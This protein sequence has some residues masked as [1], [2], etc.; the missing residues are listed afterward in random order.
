M[1]ERRFESSAD[2][3]G[4][5]FREPVSISGPNSGVA[6]SGDADGDEQ[7]GDVCRLVATVHCHVIRHSLSGT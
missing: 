3:G 5:W 6:W 1:P 4:V 2:D 7:I